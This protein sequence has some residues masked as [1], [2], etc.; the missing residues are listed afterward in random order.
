MP[1][2][3]RAWTAFARFEAVLATAAMDE[4]GK[5]AP[6]VA[7]TASIRKLSNNGGVSHAN[8]GDQTKHALHRAKPGP[9]GNASRNW[10]RVAQEGQN[11]GRNRRLTAGALKNS[12]AIFQGTRT[13]THDRPGRSPN[14]G[15]VYR[16]RAQRRTFCTAWPA[17]WPASACACSVG[18]R[19]TAGARR[20]ADRWRAR[21]PPIPSPRRNGP[22]FW[23][24]PTSR[25]LPTS[26]RPHRPGAGR[27]RRLYR[28][29]IELPARAARPRA[30]CHRGRSR[31]PTA[32][33]DSATHVATAP[34]QVVRDM[35]YP[36][37][38]CRAMVYLYLIMDLTAD[39][40][41]LLKSI[42]R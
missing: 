13:R 35:T 9:T 17:R 19:T 12:R 33:P 14:D 16:N 4:T 26:P 10:A 22:G 2:R 24:W 25:A 34:G 32:I 5:K 6:G 39:D 15:P 11:A 18:G 21:C 3:E 41:R 8:L 31:A 7:S 1:A 28:Q 29:R 42:Q 37:P 30:E 23:R 38:R 40:R 20:P 36:P 27:R